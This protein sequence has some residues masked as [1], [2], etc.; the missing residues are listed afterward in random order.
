M[1]NDKQAD[2]ELESDPKARA[3]ELDGKRTFIR[4]DSA[5]WKAIDMLAAHSC[6]DWDEWVRH[7]WGQVKEKIDPDKL[8]SVNRAGALR[9]FATHGLIRLTSSMAAMNKHHHGMS[10]GKIEVE[11]TDG[12]SLR[13]TR[14]Q[15]RAV[16]EKISYSLSYG[17]VGR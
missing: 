9:F 8:P 1:T 5:T 15:A 6:C 2:T 16:V 3:L 14:E 17:E 7:V 11:I 12:V 10:D 4:L 13:L